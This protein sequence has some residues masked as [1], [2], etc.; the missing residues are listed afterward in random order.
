[1]KQQ[2]E[3]AYPGRVYCPICTH[4]VAGEVKLVNKKPSVIPGQKCA[5]CHSA[6]D[7]G[8]VVLIQAAA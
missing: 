5:R 1:M 6:L 7:A 2:S 3:K 4:T 8:I